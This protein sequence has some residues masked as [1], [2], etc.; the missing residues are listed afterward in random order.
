MSDYNNTEEKTPATGVA[1]TV[2]GGFAT[3]AVLGLFN[4]G[5]FGGTGTNKSSELAIENAVLKA[6][7]ETDKKLVEVYKA[8]A[9]L[10]KDL[11]LSISNLSSRVL[12]LETAGPL[13]EQL[14]DQKIARVTDQMSCCCNASNQAI[15][16]LQA[17]I[18][19]L[20]GLTKTVIPADNVCPKPMPQ[21]NSWV[22]P[23]TPTTGA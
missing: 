2:L 18:S 17:E 15:T 22:A 10:D 13:K 20:Q 9:A 16:T 14:F 21:Y 12:A 11:S 8:S 1:G 4:G 19:A 7:A 23:T 3:A 5:L 6:N